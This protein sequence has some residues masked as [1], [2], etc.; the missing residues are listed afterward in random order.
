MNRQ[1]D[2]DEM[3][4]MLDPGPV[5]ACV[6]ERLAAA[7]AQL[8]SLPQAAENSAPPVRRAHR[9]LRTAAVAAAL[10]A[11]LS[12]TAL[13]ASGQLAVMAQGVIEFFAG[14]ED[15][16]LASMQPALEAYT[17]EVGVSVTDEGVTFTAD[18]VSADENFINLFGTVH[19]D[20]LADALRETGDSRR[21]SDAWAL[22]RMGLYPMAQIDGALYGTQNTLSDT[23]N[24]YFIDEDTV[25]W[26]RR[27]VL[28]GTLPRSMRCR[29]CPAAPRSRTAA[30]GPALCRS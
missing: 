11:A 4:R 12:V 30:A 3:R 18:S 6:D 19:M 7:Y 29:C 14:D 8:R 16:S 27:I 13:A 21:Q 22:T 28:D 26:A 15:S 5:P 9:L 24:A 10:C 23:M 20:G 17:A 2:R 1:K 25:G